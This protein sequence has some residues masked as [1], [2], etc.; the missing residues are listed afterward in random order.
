MQGL[1]EMLSSLVYPCFCPYS[2]RIQVSNALGSWS[3]DGG[4]LQLNDVL[5]VSTN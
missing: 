1:L 4:Y 5:S 2:R 3:C